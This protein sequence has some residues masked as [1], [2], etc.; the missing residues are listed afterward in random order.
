MIKA[1]S[2]LGTV[3]S[4]DSKEIETPKI[5]FTMVKIIKCEYLLP[6][7]M[8]GGRAIHSSFSP[9]MPED[10]TTTLEGIFYIP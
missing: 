3:F 4:D 9:K 2:L 10:C 1:F 5:S 7:W 6:I 8:A